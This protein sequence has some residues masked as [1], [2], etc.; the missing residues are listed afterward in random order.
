MNKS[1]RPSRKDLSINRRMNEKK[2]KGRNSERRE[3][4]K[5]TK[6]MPRDGLL[7]LSE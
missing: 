6:L 1:R 2:R 5:M 4:W 7:G 3:E